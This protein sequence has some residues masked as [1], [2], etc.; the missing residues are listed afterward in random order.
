MFGNTG[1]S[2]WDVNFR[3][4]GIPVQISPFFWVIALFFSPLIRVQIENG[5]LWMVGMAA[6]IL[7]WFT[8]FIIHEM[9]HALVLKRIFGADPWIILYGFGGMACHHPFYRRTP[10]AFGRILISFAGPGMEILS[11][12][13]LI[14]ILILCGFH[15]SISFSELGVLKIPIVS[16][17]NVLL[18]ML[19]PENS[20]YCFCGWFLYSFIWMSL[21]WSALNLLPIYPLDGGNIIREFFTY[22]DWRHGL[23]NSLWLS[24]I[25]A[26][27][28]AFFCFRQGSIFG[29]LMFGFF[30]F[31][32]LQEL[33]V[34]GG[35]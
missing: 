1:R 12:A 11:A 13:I 17:D 6:W 28:M 31:N 34:R 18:W 35:R 20:F 9:G 21:F 27:A 33:Q 26:G 7:A 8:T 10:G 23:G 15:P 32:N 30:A 3:L 16:F 2:A 14:L 4:L 5:R 29:A 24:I 25:C 19:M 22:F